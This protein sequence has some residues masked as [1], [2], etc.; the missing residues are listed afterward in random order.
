MS[1]YIAGL[2]QFICHAI[3]AVF[4]ML[5]VNCWQRGPVEVIKIF[6]F[7]ASTTIAEVCQHL[8]H[9]EASKLVLALDLYR[10]LENLHQK[11]VSKF[12]CTTPWLIEY[13]KTRLMITFIVL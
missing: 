5:A 12:N 1:F 8:Y 9:F 7:E 4:S 11:L 3:A 10:R 6:Y 2:L 13:A